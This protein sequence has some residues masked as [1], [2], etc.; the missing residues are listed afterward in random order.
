MKF[1]IIWSTLF[2]L[3][4]YFKPHFAGKMHFNCSFR[5][6]WKFKLWVENLREDFIEN[7]KREIIENKITIYVFIDTLRRHKEQL[8]ELFT[9]IFREEEKWYKIIDSKPLLFFYLAVL[10]ENRH[11]IITFSKE[12]QFI[13]KSIFLEIGFKSGQMWCIANGT[14]ESLKNFRG[15]YFSKLIPMNC[16]KLFVKTSEVKEG[17]FEPQ[18]LLKQE[19]ISERRCDDES[20]WPTTIK[21]FSR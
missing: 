7:F 8:E 14:I 6:E 10:V 11:K 17:F 16:S 18:K 21:A 5:K 4:L 15:S 19:I 2:V 3:H 12:K 9:N 20:T 13:P 1:E